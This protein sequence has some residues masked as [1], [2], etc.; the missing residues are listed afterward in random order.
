M[1]AS[2]HLRTVYNSIAQIIRTSPEIGQNITRTQCS[3][4]INISTG[5]GTSVPIENKNNVIIWKD[6]SHDRTRIIHSRKK[7]FAEIFLCQFYLKMVMSW[8]TSYSWELFP[9]FVEFYIITMTLS[10]LIMIPFTIYTHLPLRTYRKPTKKLKKIHW[11]EKEVSE[12]TKFTNLWNILSSIYIFIKRIKKQTIM[13]MI[14]NERKRRK[15]ER[16]ENAL[17]KW[18]S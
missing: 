17:W 12:N 10:Y 4:F 11:Q 5:F 7:S 6:P 1:A 18:C 3:S 16:R 2:K 14:K 9:D 8:N 15:E 13:R